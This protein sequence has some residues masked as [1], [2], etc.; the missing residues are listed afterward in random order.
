MN[1]AAVL[2]L[3]LLS[4]CAALIKK[5]DSVSMTGVTASVFS[6]A[7]RRCKAGDVDGAT[8]SMLLWWKPDVAKMTM[9]Q[10]RR[11]LDVC[12][13]QHGMGHELGMATEWA[14]RCMSESNCGSPPIGQV[15]AQMAEINSESDDK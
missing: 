3:A 5:V 4:P 13:M 9:E 11:L 1:F 15:F 2:G 8:Q 12:I 14:K 6:E 10:S 7:E